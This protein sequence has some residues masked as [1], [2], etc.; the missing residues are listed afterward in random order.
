MLG[1][2]WESSSYLES[3]IVHSRNLV[4]V[5]CAREVMSGSCVGTCVVDH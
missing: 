1:S 2:C 3:D 5:F 4:D